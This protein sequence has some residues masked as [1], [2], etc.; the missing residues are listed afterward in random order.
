MNDSATLLIRA[1]TREPIR[2]VPQS[3]PLDGRKVALGKKLFHE[4]ALSKDNTVSCVSCHDLHKGG[5]DRR[6]RSVGIHQTEGEINAP[7]VF[8]SGMH[9]KQFWDGRADTLA[10]QVDGPIQTDK[11][12]GSTWPEIVNKL[13]AIPAYATAFHEIYPDGI[14]RANVKDAIAEFE[15]SLITPNSRFDKYL[16]GDNA[17]I[18]DDE[19]EGYRKFKG[20]GCITCHQGANVGGNLFQPLGVMG[21]YFGD[22]GNITK[23]DLGRYNVTGNEEDK[24]T[25]KVPGLRNIALTA[26]Y[27][28][29][30]SAQTLEDAVAVMAKYQLDRELPPKDKEQ[31]V[32]FLKS[33]TGE[34]NGKLLE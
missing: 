13:Q 24:F 12:M 28:H 34:Y 8:N 17:A 1:R 4:T 32:L 10:D 20:Y 19:K 27:F 14:Q 15:K 3:I 5:T 7:T 9:F 25:F 23:A 29:D 18:T 30:G 26:P 22:R 11:E 6:V 33:L 2:P 31:I 21:D 16:R